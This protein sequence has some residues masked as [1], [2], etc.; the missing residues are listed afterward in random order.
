MLAATTRRALPGS[1]RR[2][3]R[4][5]I[6]PRYPGTSGSTH[7]AR[8][9]RKPATNAVS[10]AA[11]ARFDP[12]SDVRGRVA[13]GKRKGA[14]GETWFPA[15][16]R[17]EGERQSLVEALELLV[18]P[19]LEGG[20][21]R[22]SATAR[23]R[24]AGSRPT[25][26]ARPRRARSARTP[27]GRTQAQIGLLRGVASTPGPNWS[28]SSRLIWAALAPA[29]MRAGCTPSSGGRRASRTDRAWCD[30]S[31]RRAVPP[32]RGLG[33][34]AAPAEVAPTAATA[35]SRATTSRIT[36]AARARRSG[37]TARRCSQRPHRR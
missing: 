36:A 13:D 33:R 12:G 23:S 24:V 15:R 17:A 5:P 28:T 16:E 20:V 25:R 31:G 1:P 11:G 18:D 22:R 35:T 19:L 29:A 21:E 4:R 30:T 9:E 32:G 3:A 2:S 14:R 26:G 34:S 6:P 37:G 10:K 8:K 7:G 27:S